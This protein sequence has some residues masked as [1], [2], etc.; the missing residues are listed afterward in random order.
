MNSIHIIP[1]CV[2]VSIKA[3]MGDYINLEVSHDV[4]E[5]GVVGLAL[6][7]RDAGGAASDGSRQ[8]RLHRTLSLELKF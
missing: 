3:D 4:A 1:E 8:P 5:G 7:D 6:G 2:C